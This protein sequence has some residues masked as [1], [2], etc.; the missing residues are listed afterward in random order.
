[1]ERR[2]LIKYSTVALGTLLALTVLSDMTKTSGGGHVSP[3]PAGFEELDRL[4]SRVDR[5][6]PG[7][8]AFARAASY[9]ES[10][11]NNLAANRSASEA[12]AAC[13]GYER[14]KDGMFKNNP[15]PASDWCWGSGGWFGLLPSTGLS[16][17]GFHN[18]NPMLVFDP[19]ASIAMF[20]DMVNRIVKGQ[21]SKL[22]ESERNWLA[23]RRFMASNTVGLDWREEKILNTDTDGIP[24]SRKV[25]EKLAKHM[26]AV[27]VPTSHMYQ[28]VT[29]NGFP[30]AS[31][32]WRE[33]R[34]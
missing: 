33:L 30:G 15:Y 23:I 11:G 29:S 8:S 31:Q 22:P 26:T 9:G 25:R 14:N 17:S 19:A 1:M 10:R 16:A 2:D 13:R 24:R 21:W 28:R 5:Y 32:L 34:A 12:D 18:E 27:G 4:A 20:A 6:I 7:F 3:P